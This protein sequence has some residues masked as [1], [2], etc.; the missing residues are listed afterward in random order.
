MPFTFG[1]TPDRNKLL[2]CII[3]D[4]IESL[5]QFEGL[6]EE[7]D[8]FDVDLLSPFL[9]Q[10]MRIAHEPHVQSK[11]EDAVDSMGIAL[12]SNN[13]DEKSADCFMGERLIY[14]GF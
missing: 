5:L 7:H 10:C 11:Y 4:R 14:H 9:F 8:T 1:C 13:M 2:K 12:I 3:V 6:D